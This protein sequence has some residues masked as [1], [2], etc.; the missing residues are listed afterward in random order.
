MRIISGQYRG[1]KL[2][3]PLNNDIRPTSEMVK[4]ALFSILMNNIY[5][6]V[7][8]D[9]FSG[10][11]AVGL[12][13]A[14]RGAKRVYLI[15][16]SRDSHGIIKRNINT[17]RCKENTKLI[18]YDYKAA[19]GNIS[20]KADIIFA[21]PPYMEGYN[22]EILEFVAK[23]NFLNEDGILVIEHSSKL[24]LPEKSGNLVIYKKKKYGKKSMSFYKAKNH[25]D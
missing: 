2:D 12:E 22:E 15:D 19:M 21:D 13:A 3:T 17:V 20:E 5:G 18:P 9:M 24:D 1:R 14:S 11:G 7:F 4:E 10:T 16:R 25:I 23:G 6:S 8:V